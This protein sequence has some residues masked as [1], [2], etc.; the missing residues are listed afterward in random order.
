MNGEIPPQVEQVLQDAQVPPQGVQVPI[1]GQYNEVPVVP[2][3]MTNVEI[4]KASLT[5]ARVLTTHVNR[6]IEP[7]LNVVE[8]NMTS[9]LRDFL[10][11]NPLIFLACKVG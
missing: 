8:R 4:I 6:G 11:M 3:K 7:R 9:R 10:R 5:L 1:R 2:M